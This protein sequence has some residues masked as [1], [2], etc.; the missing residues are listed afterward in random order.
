MSR[1]T[2]VGVKGF[3]GAEQPLTAWPA[4]GRPLPL[5]ALA[6]HFERICHRAP[7]HSGVIGEG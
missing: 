3:E 2:I 7:S 4:A 5:G 1:H 6:E